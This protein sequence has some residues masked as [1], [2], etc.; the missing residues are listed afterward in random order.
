MSVGT[1]HLLRNPEKLE[2]LIKELEVVP[3]NENGLLE[4]RKVRDLPY[5]VRP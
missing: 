3:R 1:Y 4:Y 5:L 2:R